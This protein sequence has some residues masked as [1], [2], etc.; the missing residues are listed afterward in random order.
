VQR[1]AAEDSVHGPFPDG[2]TVCLNCAQQ[3]PAVYPG[4]TDV[5]IAKCKDLINFGDGPLPAE[6][7][8]TFCAMNARPSTNFD[9]DACYEG[10]CT[11][12]GMPIP[13]AAD[14]RRDPEAV[15]WVDLIDTDADGNALS[16]SGDETGDFSAGAASEQLITEGD[17]WVEFEAGETGVSHIVGVRASCDTIAICPDTDGTLADIPLSLSLNRTGDVNVIENGVVV[18]GPFPPYSAGERFRIHVVEHFGTANISFSRLPAP[19]MPNTPCT[20]DSFYEHPVGTGPSYPLRVD[21]TFRET[22]ASL[23]NVTIMRIIR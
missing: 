8:D 5:C 9:K 13:T 22:N 16:F 15:V 1:D 11:T 17:A 18:A 2:L 4:P 20:E 21:A 19:C 7:V 3:I 23:Q 12:G 6:G 14:P 10:F